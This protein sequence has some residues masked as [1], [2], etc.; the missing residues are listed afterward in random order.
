MKSKSFPLKVYSFTAAFA[1]IICLSI[2]FIPSIP[3]GNGYIHVGD[4]VIY[5][6]ASVLP[7]PFGL[8]AASIG[9]AMADLMKGYVAY[10]LP[11]A[12]IKPLN[13]L[14]FL[15]AATGG[16]II[17]VRSI[18]ASVLSGLVTVIGYYLTE[19]V[20]YGNPAA[21]LATLPANAVQAGASCLIF[22]LIGLALDKSKLTR[23]LE[24]K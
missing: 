14:C 22:I 5:L 18:A 7:F 24:I 13:A 4:S 8:A 10:V 11:T 1:A 15:P 17:T 3:A 6:A 19:V 16:R 23:Y 21:Q 20:L 12:I 9:G 2:A